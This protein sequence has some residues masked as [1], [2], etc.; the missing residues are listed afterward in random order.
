MREDIGKEIGELVDILAQHPSIRAIGWSSGD[1][2]YPEPGEG[3]IDLFIYS[4]QIP[5]PDERYKML[6]SLG[7]RVKPFEVGRLDDRHWGQGDRCWVSGIE[8]WLLHFTITEACTELEAVLAGKYLGRVDND[9]YPLG[10]CAMWN[11][12]LALYDPDGILETFK[13]SLKEYPPRL[14]RAV[15]EDHLEALKDVED[16]ERATSRKDV[17]F[18][19]FAL[20]IALDHFLQ[21]LF[22]INRV[23]FPSRKRSEMFIQHFPVKP[24]GCEQ[25]LRQVVACGSNAETL[26]KSFQIWQELVRE[27]RSLIEISYPEY[28]SG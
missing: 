18:Y 26:A 3:D 22:A 14:A 19:H 21:A 10:R 1:R 20:D 6:A 5:H 11:T 13:K 28:S 2:A 7:E 17:L 15:V 27:L 4:S 25:R 24:A 12:M 16:L 23:Y 8:T 9:F